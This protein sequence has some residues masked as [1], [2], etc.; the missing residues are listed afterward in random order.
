MA[1]KQVLGRAGYRR[2]RVSTKRQNTQN[3]QN[4]QNRHY[5][6]NEQK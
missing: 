2:A 4:D 5:R 6:Q 3:R 1:R